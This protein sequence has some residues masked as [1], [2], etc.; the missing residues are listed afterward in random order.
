M[1]KAGYNDTSLRFEEGNI[2]KLRN[3]HYTST[4]AWLLRMRH[5]DLSSL[6]ASGEKNIDFKGALSLWPRG[7]NDPSLID[8]STN[9]NVEHRKRRSRQALSCAVGSEK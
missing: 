8:E 9:S 4:A 5:A 6:Y 7:R 3:A 2:I 1:V